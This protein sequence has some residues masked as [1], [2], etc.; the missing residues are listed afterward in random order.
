[1]APSDVCA[2]A[3]GGVYQ[4]ETETCVRTSSSR[5]V[6]TDIL[7]ANLLLK[8]RMRR[9]LTA[10]VGYQY[11]DYDSSLGLSLTADGRSYDDHRFRVGFSYQFGKTFF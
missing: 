4:D 8:W 7:R 3:Y 1:M 9:H 10:F 6:D 11:V 5:A 2:V